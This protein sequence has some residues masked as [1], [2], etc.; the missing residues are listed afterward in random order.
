MMKNQQRA[1]RPRRQ[2]L[3]LAAGDLDETLGRCQH[4][5]PLI[6]TPNHVARMVKLP[7]QAGICK[8]PNGI[9]ITLKPPPEGRRASSWR[10]P[11]FHFQPAP[12]LI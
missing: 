2:H 3:D 12:T 11:S 6:G 8:A 1:S 7:Y 10:M 4:V 9:T 5:P